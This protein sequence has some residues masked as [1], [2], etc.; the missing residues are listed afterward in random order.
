MGETMLLNL[1]QG[2][3]GFELTFDRMAVDTRRR[4]TYT[5]V[6]HVNRPSSTG[7]VMGQSRMA[8]AHCPTTCQHSSYLPRPGQAVRFS[9]ANGIRTPKRA[10][11]TRR[12]T[13]A[14][15]PR[16]FSTGLKARVWG[17]HASQHGCGAK[18]CLVSGRV[19]GQRRRNGKDEIREPVHGLRVV[20]LELAGFALHIGGRAD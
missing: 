18:A 20:F 9:L 12:H 5:T 17:R 2:E 14:K 11:P 6:G 1:G 19:V 16:W 3:R 13:A 4:L 8:T 15:F 10:S 7:F